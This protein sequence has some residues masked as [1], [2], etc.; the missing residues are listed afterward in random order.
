MSQ[1]LPVNK[2]EWIEDTFKFNENFVKNYNG[3]NDG[4]F[5]LEVDIQCSEKLQAFHNDL[6]F[7][8]ERMKI[9]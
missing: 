8:T 3:E 6:P 9:E 1:N 7:L 2:F 4:E 5:F